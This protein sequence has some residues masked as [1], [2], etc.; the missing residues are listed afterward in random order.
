MT[1]NNSQKKLLPNIEFEKKLREIGIRFIAGVDEAGRGPLAGPVVAAAVVFPESIFIDN[2]LP[3]P[4]LKDSKKLSNANRLKFYDIIKE[5]AVSIGIGIIN[6]E[7]I[8]QINILN[9]TFKAM[10]QAIFELK[11]LPDYLLIDGPHFLEIGIPFA[12]II[13]GDLK[14]FSI[15]AASIIAK[16]VRDNIMNDYDTLYPNYGFSKHKGY[17]TSK[18]VM[19]IKKYGYCNIHRRTF[20]INR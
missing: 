4:N 12:K 14:C 11:P 2:S 3:I 9:A 15:A 6:N 18:H 16:V 5:K 17:G 20:K 1:F 19:A 8:D 7:I 10:Q 13:N